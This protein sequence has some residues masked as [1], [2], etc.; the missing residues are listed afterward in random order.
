MNH[1]PDFG[2]G[3][4]RQDAAQ[5]SQAVIQLIQLNWEVAHALRL[6]AGR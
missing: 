5:N 6:W 1:D 3:M 2:A 4:V